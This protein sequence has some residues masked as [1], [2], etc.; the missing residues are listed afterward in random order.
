VDTTLPAAELLARCL[1]IE[2]ALGRLR[3]PGG[4]KAARTV[5]I[6]L[7]LYGEAIL[8]TPALTVPHPELLARPFV[9]IPLAD[10]AAPGLRHPITGDALDRAAPS[11]AVR[12]I[13]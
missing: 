7:L 6:D 1:S 13:A 11:A 5:D 10:V 12:R 9:R 3:P 8:S 4:A 2:S